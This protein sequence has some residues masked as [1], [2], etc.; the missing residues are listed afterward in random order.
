MGYYSDIKLVTTA[1]GI[2][3]LKRNMATIDIDL[4]QWADR[5]VRSGYADFTLVVWK[6]RKWY[7]ELPEIN[8]FYFTLAQMKEDR[9]PYNY[10]RIGEDL[11]EGDIETKFFDPERVLPAIY[12]D[13]DIVLEYPDD[14]YMY[15]DDR[16]AMCD[17]VLQVCKTVEYGRFVRKIEYNPEL[18]S[19][20]V[21]VY[22]KNGFCY[23]CDATPESILQTIKEYY[24][25]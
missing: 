21:R 17:A 9:I 5:V 12:A 1:K 6:F 14:D 7:P 18:V 13:A 10:I 19:K 15:L 20:P 3:R 24:E 8:I 22:Q 25:L 2:E 4:D 11:N 23:D 16:Q